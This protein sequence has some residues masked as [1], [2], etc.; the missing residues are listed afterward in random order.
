MRCHVPHPLSLCSPSLPSVPS[1]PSPLFPPSPPDLHHT[2]SYKEEF[3]EN[4]NIL[5]ATQVLPPLHR[6]NA[7]IADLTEHDIIAGKWRA[8]F[9]HRSAPRPFGTIITP[10]TRRPNPPLPPPSLP[11]NRQSRHLEP[12]DLRTRLHAAALAVGKRVHG[13]NPRRLTRALRNVLG[14]VGAAGDCGCGSAE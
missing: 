14:K 10:T 11:H 4:K 8:G 5:K 6:Q 9:R 3:L 1:A 12:R 13:R 2:T 7:H